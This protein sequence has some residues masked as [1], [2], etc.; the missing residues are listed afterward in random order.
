MKKKNLFLLTT[1]AALNLL[2]LQG[3]TVA[4]PPAGG[5]WST[6]PTFVDDFKGDTLD[7]TKWSTG[8]RFAEVIN[9]ELQGF[10]PENVT[11]ADGVCRIKAEKRPVQNT[12][13]TGHKTAKQQYASGAI[14]TYTKWA[15]G[16]GYF[17]V[18]AKMPGGKG[19]WPAFW[20]LPDRGP[21]VTNLDQ[22]VA[23]GSSV[24][25]VP[26]TPGNEI[27]IFEIMGSWVDAKGVGKSHSGYFWGY[28]G[29][30]AWGEY[31]L[32]NNGAGPEHHRV[33]N[34][35]TEFHT[36]GVAWGPGQLDFYI[37]DVKVLSRE[38]PPSLT[39]IGWAPHYMILNI[40]LKND[41]WTPKKLTL[42]EIDADLPRTMVIDYV[43][44]W[45][46]TPAPTPAPLAEGTYRIT[47]LSDATKCLQVEGASTEDGAKVNQATYTGA[48]NQQW[49][50]TYLG[51][52]VYEFKAKHSG[53]VLGTIASSGADFTKI[54]QA[55]DTDALGQ[56][57]KLQPGAPG[58]FRVTP[59]VNN[60]A[61]LSTQGKG[62]GEGAYIF[63][64]FGSAG[65]RWKFEPVNATAPATPATPPAP[66]SP[67]KPATAPVPAT[68]V[69]A[70]A[71]ATPAPAT[72]ATTTPAA[73]Q[74]ATAPAAPLG[75]AMTANSANSIT[76]SWYRSPNDDAMGYNVYTGDTK[77]GAYKRIATVTE[78]T[79]TVKNLKPG[80]TYFYK[81]STSNPNGES[82]QS[83]PSEGF[84]I[85][86][87]AGAP[88]PARV[89]KNMCVSLGSNIISNPAPISGKLA[90]LVDGSDAT[91]CRLRKNSE[92]KIKL[93]PT[94]SIADAEYLIVHFR[95]H[96]T[97]IDWSN[98]PF[99][100]TLRNYVITESLDSTD[101]KDGTWQEVATGTNSLLDGVIVIPNHKPKWIGV[102]SSGGPEIPSTDKRL[103]PSD[104]ILCR[105]DVFR[106]APAGYRNDYW[107]FTGDS[108]IVQDMPG[109]GVE[110]RSAY[111]SD[112]VRKQH[113]DRYPIV[114]HAAQGGEMLK[115]TLPR[116]KKTLE[117]LS[118]PNGTATPTATTVCWET[119]FNDVGLSAGL[120]IGPR[121]IKSLSEAQELCTA[122]GLFMVPVR[123]E[124]STGYLDLNTLEP[125][126]YNVFF[127]TLAANLSGVDPFCRKS[128][129]YA[130]DP[131]TQLPYADYWNYTRKNYATALAKDGV[132][133]TKAGSDGINQLW[134]D[135]ADKMIYARQP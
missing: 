108:L 115:D 123:I 73:A 13:M 30:S 21:A 82:P 68:P 55:L 16:Y 93:Q 39:K 130:C 75:V 101:G 52:S 53:K 84:T 50:L 100:R 97:A 49:D 131:Q 81:V 78:R 87:T 133:H 58:Y 83:P 19:T 29:K 118:P 10:V 20:L 61:A 32:A 24:K 41:D 128:T 57:W 46:G 91:T 113:P 54:E 38:E 120:W 67:T 74:A 33:P 94:P 112:L 4:A 23:V 127:N 89:A 126:K 26:I 111:F 3:A 51:G 43:K 95:T 34:Q 85:T 117:S 65:Q 132:H 56:R 47:P 9:N 62:E 48:A 92:I 12:G 64:S 99:A 96:G 37:D 11:V 102:R 18:R 1:V 105:L 116:M 2:A 109:G 106:S 90:D 36:Y 63:F 27:D 45:S 22:R 107:I 71:P 42:E 7:K 124:Y 40:A 110:G 17:E 5:N 79:A 8:Y 129:P 103:M 28:D 60:K 114:V 88:F 44:V 119:G 6:E 76:L 121:L 104:L 77:D 35:D 14:Q 98:D 80:T 86:P 59:W 66:A 25:G 70:P 69:A 15:Q 134:A 125:A 122:S 72:P 31:A 135:V